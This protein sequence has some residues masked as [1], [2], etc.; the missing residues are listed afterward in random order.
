MVTLGDTLAARGQLYAAQFCY[1]VSA[2]EFGTFNKKSSKV[3]SCC[4]A[5]FTQR[6]DKSYESNYEL[7]K[8]GEV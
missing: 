3:C 5:Y 4:H 1:I 7:L 6:T 8:E 2:V